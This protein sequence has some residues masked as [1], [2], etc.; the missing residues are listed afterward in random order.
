MIPSK[1]T[2]G[3]EDRCEWKETSIAGHAAMRCALTAKT[4]EA[5]A[6]LTHLQGVTKERD[7]LRE[8]KEQAIRMFDAKAARRGEGKC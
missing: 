8:W 4:E 2:C 5:A 3:R 1:E 7:Q 6:L